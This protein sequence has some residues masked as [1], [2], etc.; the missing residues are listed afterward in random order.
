MK[1]HTQALGVVVCPHSIVPSTFTQVV[2]RACKSVLLSNI[3]QYESSHGLLE[4]SFV[5]DLGCF[6]CRGSCSQHSRKGY[7]VNSCSQSCLEK[8]ALEYDGWLCGRGVFNVIRKRQTM[9]QSGP[10]VL[11]FPDLI[12]DILCFMV[13]NVLCPFS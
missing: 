2:S 6:H 3:R 13:E 9:F 8:N 4:L 1:V 7:G 12:Y 11:P 5:D 10:I